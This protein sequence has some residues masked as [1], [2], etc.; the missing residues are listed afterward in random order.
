M[1]KRRQRREATAALG[2]GFRRAR[3]DAVAAP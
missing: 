1:A 2:L 3:V